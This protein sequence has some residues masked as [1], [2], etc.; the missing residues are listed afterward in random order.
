MPN[1]HSPPGERVSFS[2][3]AKRKSP[4]RRP[5][6]SGGLR[7]FG[8][9]SCVALPPASMQSPALRLRASAPGFADNTSMCWQQTG[10]NPLRPPCGPFLRPAATAYG[11]LV[12]RIVRAEAEAEA[13]A[14]A[15]TEAYRKPLCLG[16]ARCAVSGPPMRRQR[17]GGDCMDAGG[18]APQEQLPSVLWGFGAN[19][20]TLGRLAKSQSRTSR[21]KAPL[22]LNRKSEF[23][24]RIHWQTMAAYT[25]A[26]SSSAANPY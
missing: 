13:K 20:L 2:C 5:P 7:A 11:T 19:A 3:V 12:A 22:H 10:R 24:P 6:Q 14:K 17:D 18:R 21:L 23:S 26:A 8:N 15:E 1:I 25:A 4:K 9:C 16:C